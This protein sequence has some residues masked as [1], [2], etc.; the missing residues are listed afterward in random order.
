MTVADITYE[1]LGVW[2]EADET[3]DLRKFVE[4]LTSPVEGIYD[5]VRDTDDAPSWST[6]F[7]P[8][9]CPVENLPYLAQFVG[10]EL[11]ESMTETEKREAITEP[12]GFARGTPAAIRIAITRTLTGTKRIVIKEREP[13]AY[14]VYIRTFSAETPSAAATEAAIRAVKPAGLVLDYAASTGS[15]F[16][17][18][19]ADFATYSA[20]DAAYSTYDELESEA[21]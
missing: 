18:L 5:R 16:T 10:V 19:D 1:A 17:D 4:A 6:L 13:S 14:G 2:A 3:G 11:T 8:A 15:T 21:L 12:V 20:L 9:T 7:D